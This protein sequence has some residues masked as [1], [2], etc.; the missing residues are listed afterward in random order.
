MSAAHPPHSTGAPV[1][2]RST[3]RGAIAAALPAAALL[4]ASL[5][6]AR[7]A[8]A[9]E[10]KA[11]TARLG[12]VVVTATKVAVPQAARTAAV[13]V[14]GGAELR[15]RGVVELGDALRTLPGITV[16]QSGSFGGATSL[17]LRGGE[18]DYV[19]VL[20]DGVPLNLSGGALDLAGLTTDN[21][22]RIEVVRGPA[23][24][25]YGS[26]AV[27]GVVQIF[28]RD[29]RGPASLRADV[30]GGTYGTLNA[31]A[32]AAGRAGALGWSLGGAR[33]RTNGIYDFNSRYG[34]GS[35]G[36]ALHLGTAG[37]SD[38]RVS[39]RHRES[40]YHYPTDDAGNAV[41]HDANARTIGTTVGIDAGAFVL[42][43]LELRAIA[44]YNDHALRDVDRPD[45]AADPNSSL[46]DTRLVRRSVELRANAYAPGG[47]VA[48]LGGSYELEDESSDY[49]STSQWGPYDAPPFS[50]RRADRALYGQLLGDVAGALSWT[51]GGRYDD[52]DVFGPFRTGRVGLGW[53][54]GRGARLRAAYGTAF[55]EP[56][57]YETYTP[58]D[59]RPVNR[60]LRPERSRSWEVGV[61][62][63][64]AGGRARVGA[65]YF[66]QQFRDMIGYDTT[67]TIGNID[68]ARAR[69]VEL[70]ASAFGVAGVDLRA[71]YT[72][73][74]ARRLDAATGADLGAL[75]RR[76][77]R[78]ASL[79][80]TRRFGAGGSVV[81]TATYVG[82]R[83]DIAFRGFTS[84]NVK[85]PAYTVLDLAATLPLV[86]RPGTGD[87][88][89][90]LRVAN[91]LGTHYE[92]VVNYPA[93][94]R[95]VLVGLRLG[96][97]R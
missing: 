21:V 56:T 44:G 17:F 35:V 40:L 66:D 3:R 28:T 4:A 39:A 73:L 5:V 91:V 46:Y 79:D 54:L 8:R 88:A 34:N 93:P 65:T 85:A 59:P 70:E 77:S 2:T 14:V 71:S 97:G 87:A 81:A 63:A 64:L 30:R 96:V 57:L 61:E 7:A 41:D 48:T 75:L 80:V 1:T 53:Q 36:G 55:K 74:R 82:D 95:M 86:A 92:P 20:V 19:K 60:D 84:E 15:A 76:P 45:S 16:V 58:G 69:G 62:Q 68:R 42:P 51:V 47:V 33:E 78:S 11:D 13:S 29:G 50:F 83:R 67:F 37:R 94:G 27:T 25:L 31:E 24:V 52:N 26:D 89:L 6:T 23:S 43:R 38:L 32:S 72:A 49:A 18:S 22:D 10:A 12:A 90:T 9:Q